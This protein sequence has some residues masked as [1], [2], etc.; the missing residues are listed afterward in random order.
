MEDGPIEVIKPLQKLAD[1]MRSCR[2][3]AREL[4]AYD[5]VPRPIFGGGEGFP[6]IL[7]G[8]A[9]GKTEYER[10]AP[11]QGDAGQ[12]IKALFVACGLTDFDRKVYQTSVTKCFPGRRA[13]ATTDRVPGVGEVNNCSPFL[14]RQIELL[15]P[16][17]MV[18]LGG[19]AWKAYVSIREREEPGCCE[20]EFGKKKPSELRVPDLVGRRFEWKGTTVVPMI[21]PAGS[22]NGSRADYPGQDRESKRLLR[23]E[24]QRI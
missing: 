17:L 6:I 7:I 20:K 24:I 8:Q 16:K 9:P 10:N 23:E 19:L 22:A 12:S 3:C 5:V 18:C 11:F 13:K 4:S 1:E 15:R 14:V 21:H 2:R